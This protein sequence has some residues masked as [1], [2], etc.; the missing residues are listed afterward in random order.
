M[1]PQAAYALWA[2]QYPPRPHNPLMEVE[3]AALTSLIA[4]VP[5]PARALDV[6]S[7]T[8]RYLPLIGGIGAR[9]V[10]GLDL[11]MPMLT[12]QAHGAP[13]VCA[14]AC[15]LPFGDG[16]FGLVTAS[17]MVGDVE[18][19]DLWVAEMSRVL[20]TGGH[21]IYSDF[22]PAWSQEGWR[23]TFRATDG[24]LVEVGYWP[25]SLDAHLAALDGAALEVR[26]I[27]EPRHHGRKPPVVIAFHA[28]R[29]GPLPAH[30]R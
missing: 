5:A 9:V 18:R 14:D 7:G 1:D 30:L 13:R 2:E 21:L 19:L 3:Q 22:H 15:R 26:T 24:R 25:H 27:R 20:A 12:R 8:G 6:G 10:V 23:R 11:S 4:Q 16:R 28:L 29:R 17:L